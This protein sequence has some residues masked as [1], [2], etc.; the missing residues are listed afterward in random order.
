M[1]KYPGYWCTNHKL[2]NP[3]VYRSQLEIA[4]LDPCQMDDLS[5][6]PSNFALSGSQPQLRPRACRFFAGKVRKAP[7]DVSKYP[8]PSASSRWRCF[9]ALG[10]LSRLRGFLSSLRQMARHRL[11][12]HANSCLYNAIEVR[13]VWATISSSVEDPPRDTTHELRL[14]ML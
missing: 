2:S 4:N 6:P 14:V 11:C 10:L 5:G 7:T 9:E 12:Q 3:A 8:A 1:L 13:S